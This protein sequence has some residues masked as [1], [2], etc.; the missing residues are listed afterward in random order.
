MAVLQDHHV[1]D[2]YDRPAEVGRRVSTYLAD[3]LARGET[4]IVIATPEHRALFVEGLADQGIDVARCRSEGLLFESDAEALLD[5]FFINGTVDAERFDSS[6]GELVRST[7]GR[8]A[9]RIV[10]EMVDL[11]CQRGDIVGGLSLESEWSDLA[12]RHDFTLYCCYHADSVLGDQ[13]ALAGLQEIHTQVVSAPPAM[14]WMTCRAAERFAPAAASAR[15]ARL[16]VTDLL[17]Q[18]GLQADLDPAN[19]IVSELSTN[20]VLHAGTPFEVVVSLRGGSV[21]RIAVRDT[22]PDRPVV[23]APATTEPGGRGMAIVASLASD[24]AVEPGPDGKTVWADI[25]I[26]QS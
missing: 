11:L 18:W 1:V 24:W 16:F 17:R 19:M 22:S 6:V 14:Q 2:I 9:V 12:K 7:T 20:S 8:P 21:L 25:A 10:G 5:R 13:D 4:S 15:A 3:G 23:R 26:S